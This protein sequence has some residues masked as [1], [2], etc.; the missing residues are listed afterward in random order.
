MRYG[1]S[2][3]IDYTGMVSELEDR[4]RRCENREYQFCVE[5]AVVHFSVFPKLLARPSLNFDK[6]TSAGRLKI[7][8]RA[9]W[10]VAVIA[11]ALFSFESFSTNVVLLPHD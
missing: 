10:S 11:R 4:E 8:S 6:V 1:V 2:R 7:C 9:G 3:R 5:F